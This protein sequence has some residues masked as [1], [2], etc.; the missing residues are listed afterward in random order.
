MGET[1]PV[2]LV[3]A[4]ASPARLG[5]LRAAGID[6][7]VIVSGV[8]ET[9]VLAPDVPSLV[10]EL[11]RRKAAA[12]ATGDAVA[13]G[14]LVLGCDSLLDVDG[15]AHGKPGDAPAALRRWQRIR[16]HIGRLHTGHCLIA[17]GSGRRAEQVATTAVRFGTPSD[18]EIAAYVATGEPLHVAGGFTLDGRAAPFIEGVDGD[19]SNVIGLSLPT[20]RRLLSELDRSIVELWTA[21]D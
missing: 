9:A 21:P 7:V 15:E 3:L 18:A 8:D 6:P 2:R 11:A 20:L 1:R 19:P 14:D 17:V 5:L 16:G 4:S 12:V 10:A 13:D